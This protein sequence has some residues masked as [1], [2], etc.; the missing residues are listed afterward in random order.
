MPAVPALDAASILK[1]MPG[2]PG[3]VNT[4]GCSAS[5]ILLPSVSLA[6]DACEASLKKR[7]LRPSPHS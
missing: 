2:I 3:D 7:I 1:L 4:A 6:R 5:F